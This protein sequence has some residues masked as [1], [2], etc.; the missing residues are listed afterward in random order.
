MA[1]ESITGLG[2][3]P[4]TTTVYVGV[5]RYQSL[6][7]VAIEASHKSG[8]LINPSQVLHYLIDNHLDL[9]KEMLIRDATKPKPAVDPIKQ[10]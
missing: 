2:P 7:A 4:K 6:T 9:I 5:P 3:G 10:S 8:R 1:S